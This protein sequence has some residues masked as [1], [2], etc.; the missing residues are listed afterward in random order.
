MR[1][2]KRLGAYLPIV[3]TAFALMLLANAAA[4]R[5]Q[6]NLKNLVFDQFQRWRPR[7]YTF[8]QPIRIVDIDDKSIRR[9]GQWPWPREK[10][11]ELVDSLH[12]A[13]VAAVSLN[14]LF[15]EKERA[16]P[17]A[18]AVPDGVVKGE[19]VYTTASV[20]PDDGDAVFAKSI[21]NNKVVLGSILTPRVMGSVSDVKG[22][23]AAKCFNPADR[24]PPFAGMLSPVATLA[25]SAT[26]IGFMNWTPNS[27]RVVR[28]MP[29]LASVASQLQPSFILE[30]LRV[31]QGASTYLIKCDDGDG[32]TEAGIASI[33][34]GDVVIATQPSGDIRAYFAPADA[35]RSIPAWELFETGADLGDLEGKIAVIG[36]SASL[37]GDVVAT[38]L[39]PSTPGVE[40]VAQV[41]EQILSGVTL[42]RPDWAPGAE[43]LAA[44]TL[45]LVLVFA[46]PAIP[47]LWSALLVAV[48]AAFLCGA[49]WIAFT[50]HGLL[51]DPVV[52]SVSSAVVFLV[53]ILT[54]YSQKLKQVTEIRSAFGRYVSPAV[55]AQLAE[56]P[57]QLRLGGLQRP[58]TVMFCDIRSFT[59]ISEGF[60][61]TQLTQFLNEYLTPMTTVI[62]DETGTVDKYMGDAVMAFWNAP[63]DD[64]EH[65]VHAVR[66]ALR[67]RQ[68]LIDLNRRWATRAADGESSFGPVRFGIGLNTGIC[69]VG[70]M[71]SDQRFD[72]SAMGDEVNIASRL[73]GSSKLFDVDIVASASTRDEAADFAWLEIDQV[74]LKGRTRTTATYALA[75]DVNYAASIGFRALSQQHEAMLAAYRRRDFGVAQRLATEAAD[76]AP[77]EVKGL[78]AFYAG[79]LAKLAASDLAETWRPMIALTEK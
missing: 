45:S 79:R 26:G 70:N 8:D 66:A 17:G 27:D 75:G 55:V 72:Y 71:G 73:E 56:N 12:R 51:L 31:A 13:H 61:A 53:G 29:L 65:A 59:T 60:S 77:P 28:R 5:F 74:L 44:A 23:F 14:V 67:M 9:I 62:L 78:Y 35:R 49:S 1:K 11:A 15:S 10:M 37:L 54:L 39:N 40:A 33:R 30:S 48:A 6:S 3:V 18:A 64:P 7:P 25:D 68:A 69:S 58:L 52:P 50:Q 46:M 16:S 32:R 42:R 2:R 57:E 63:L 36:A 19:A 41:L 4:T 20:R 22:G 34:D 43:L 24:V 21:F 76:L 47:A 38:P